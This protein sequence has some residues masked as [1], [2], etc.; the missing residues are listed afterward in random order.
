MV[1]GR[2]KYRTFISAF[3]RSLRCKW[4]YNKRILREA[5]FCD[6]A[7]IRLL[8]YRGDEH[9][10]DATD[11]NPPSQHYIAATINATVL[12]EHWNRIESTDLSSNIGS[13]DC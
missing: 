7:R 9:V 10:R 13:P 12:N 4:H 1:L 11:P 6:C 2:A 3:M 5:V 8:H